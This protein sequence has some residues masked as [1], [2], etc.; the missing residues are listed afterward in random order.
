MSLGTPHYMSPEQA[1]GER[2]LDAR[3]D[4]YALGC[5]LYEMLVGEPPFTGP[6]GPGDR[7]QGDDRPSRAATHARA[8]DRAAARRGCGAHGAARSSRPTG[9]PARPSSRRRWRIRRSAPRT[10][11]AT[12]G[13]GLRAAAG[14]GLRPG[15]A[16]GTGRAAGGDLALAGRPV[17]ARRPERAVG[18]YPLR[19]RSRPGPVALRH[20]PV[21]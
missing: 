10:T 19:G 5:V 17:G 2:E 6:D 9:S 14:H 7:G 20:P 4:V 21:W 16:L 11:R 15:A 1:M 8:T 18:A 13:T 12:R 3:T